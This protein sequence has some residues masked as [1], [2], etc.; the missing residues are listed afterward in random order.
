M[1]Q[2]TLKHPQVK[3]LEEQ[4]LTVLLKNW[5]KFCKM[6]FLSALEMYCH[7]CKMKQKELFYKKK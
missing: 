6:N 3:K 5:L 1:F 4:S 7:L 2:K